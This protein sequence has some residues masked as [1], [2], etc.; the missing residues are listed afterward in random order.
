MSTILIIDDDIASCRMLQMHFK[1]QGHQITLAHSVDEGLARKGKINP[2]VIILDI[3]MPGRS[4]LEALPD[5]KKEFS[6]S[7]IIMITAFHDMNSTIQAMKDGADD[8]IHKPIDLT[9][10]EE[11]VNKALISHYASDDDITIE[12]LQASDS[13]LNTM[14]GSSFAM[15]DIY[16]TIGRVSQSPASVLITGESGTGKELVA[17]AIH[18]SSERAAGPFIAINCAALVETLLESDMFGH[19]K[20]SFTGAVNKQTGK[21]AL[22]N[23]GTIFLDEVGE[24]SLTMQAKLL[25]VLQEKEFISVGGKTTQNTNARVIAATNVNFSEQ[26]DKGLFREDLFYRLQVVTI[27]IPPLR[28]RREDIFDLT[29][30]LL[31]R[32][33]KEMNRNVNRVAVDVMQALHDYDWPGNIRELENILIK[34]VAMS[35]RDIITADLLPEKIIQQTITHPNNF[36]FE[37][38]IEKQ[39]DDLNHL[40][41][42]DVEKIH[43]Q[44]ILDSTNGHKGKACD[45]LGISRPRLRRLIKQ[46]D[47]N[48]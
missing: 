6:N 23:N 13:P 15:R 2:E 17:R 1:A 33:N 24:L 26:I 44:R 22:A 45:I 46:Y 39:D 25:R 34:S 38:T 3:R 10:L 14:V 12:A 7:R 48:G 5:I 28:E 35:P 41:I 43:I 20:G 30:A 32:A 4:G 11:A 27:H 42:Q 9:E 29:Q 40:S 16:K 47:L 21:F 36:K 31:G 8:Y 18:L 37:T 19:E